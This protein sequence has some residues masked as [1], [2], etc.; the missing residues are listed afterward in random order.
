MRF[1]AFLF[2]L[3]L[4]IVSAEPP[5]RGPYK[6]ANV[7]YEVDTL[8][9]TMPEVVVVY[10]IRILGNE[11]FPFISFNHGAGSGGLQTYA[12]HIGILN[13]LASHGFIVGATKSCMIGCSEGFWTNYWEEQYKVIEWAQSEEMRNDPI[14]GQVNHDLGYGIAGHS[15][16]GQATARSATRASAQN[17]KAA[18]LYH[19]YHQR[20]EEIGQDIDVPL[21]GFTGTLDTCCGEESTRAYYDDAPTPKTFADMS[22]ALHTEPNAPNSR[23]EAYSA[24]WF[25]IWINKDN[26]TYYDLI[27]DDSNPDSLCNF[28][29]MRTCEHGNLKA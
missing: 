24:A 25:Q 20:G 4:V 1:C 13:G 12:L 16:G 11:T 3:L 5:H 27:Y 6:T 22:G 10:P 28:Y 8:D 18:I 7:D 21:A 26:G 19:P 17:V 14:L 9:E 15:M 29:D 23:W 2:A